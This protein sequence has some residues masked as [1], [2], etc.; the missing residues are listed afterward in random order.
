MSF[1]IPE[2]QSQVLAGKV[3]LVT[4]IANDQSIAD[5]CARALRDAG[6]SLAITY[7]NEKARPY[8]E[9]LAGAH[10]AELSLPLEVREAP[11]M[12]AVFAAIREKWGRLDFLVHSLAFAPKADLQGHLV[13]SSV[14]GFLT[15]MDISCHSFVRM[16]KLAEPLMTDGGVL[17]TMSYYGADKVIANYSL[18]GPVK[19]A[20]EDAVRYL[21]C[22]LAQRG[23]ASMPSRR[24]R[25]KHGRLP[26]LPTSMSCWP[27]PNFVLQNA[28]SS[29]SSISAPPPRFCARHSPSSSP[30]GPSMSMAAT[31]FA[32]ENGRSC[33]AAAGSDGARSY[34]HNRSYS[35]QAVVTRRNAAPC[36]IRGC[37]RRSN[38][39]D[40][41]EASVH[42][43]DRW[44]NLE[45]QSVP[46]RE[47]ALIVVESHVLP[48]ASCQTSTFSGRS[49]PIV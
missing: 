26:A 23:S 49:I 42:D 38:S 4:G 47:P 25:S 27:R 9:P 35:E 32:D 12:T 29:T 15:A 22:G 33:M 16:A 13:D 46:L 18:M 34:A 44:I 3:G 45:A 8:V 28:T 10:G 2:T 41:A 20:L 43:I 40:R 24:V 5:G 6:A 31:T 14:E 7:L 39:N 17:V 21:A 36:T 48:A 11:Q 37:G 19:A 30:A 1:H